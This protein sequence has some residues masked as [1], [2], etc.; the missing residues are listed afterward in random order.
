M[1]QLA[2]DSKG[3]KDCAMEVIII[4]PE[5][6]RGVKNY[7]KENPSPFTFVHDESH[8]IADRYQQEVNLFKLGRMPAQLVFDES[9]NRLL[10][11]HAKSMKD[12]VP[13]QSILD[14]YCRR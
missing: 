10:E 6:P 1:E 11:H 14:N 7:L 5:D 8:L 3:F 9:G 4:C 12:I 2:Q 13:N